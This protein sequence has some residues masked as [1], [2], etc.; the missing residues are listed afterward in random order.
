MMPKW[1]KP[2]YVAADHDPDYP[3]AGLVDLADNETLQ[4]QKATGLAEAWTE[5]LRHRNELTEPERKEF[6]E[7]VRVELKRAQLLVVVRDS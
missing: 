5:Y 2:L 3:R 6:L 4:F 1:V 7:W